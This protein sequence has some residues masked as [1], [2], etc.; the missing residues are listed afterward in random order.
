MALVWG[1]RLVGG[2]WEVF[3]SKGGWRTSEAGGE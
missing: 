3:L 2:G 1:G